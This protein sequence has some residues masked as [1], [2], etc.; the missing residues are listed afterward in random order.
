MGRKLKE[1]RQENTS[2]KNAIVGL[3]EKQFVE[4]STIY[5]HLENQKVL[6]SR[7]RTDFKAE[8][9]NAALKAKASLEQSI[10]VESLLC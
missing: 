10:F 9:L 2:L 6:Q 8:A 1:I 5:G 3:K 7:P 4:I